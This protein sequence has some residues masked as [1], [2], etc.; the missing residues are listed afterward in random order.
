MSFIVSK[1]G[2]SAA[3][4]RAWGNDNGFP[5]KAETRGRPS[6]AL[7]AAYNAK[8]RGALRYDPKGNPSVKTITVKAK[9]AKGRTVEKRVNVSAARAAAKAA[10]LPVGARGR[11]PQAVLSTLVL[12]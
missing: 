2:P 12:G 10:G 4:L 9:P 1:S 3:T 6:K 8:H 5:A 11:L 7:I